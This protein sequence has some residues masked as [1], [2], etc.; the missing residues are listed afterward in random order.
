[1][2]PFEEQTRSVDDPAAQTDPELS[3]TVG[4]GFDPARPSSA[5]WPWLRTKKSR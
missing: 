4:M 3:G 1:M 2:W 5:P